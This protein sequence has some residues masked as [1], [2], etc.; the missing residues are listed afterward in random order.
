MI[1]IE[2]NGSYDLKAISYINSARKDNHMWRGGVALS[3]TAW[4]TAWGTDE[5]PL[6]LDR[7]HSQME[8]SPK[9]GEQ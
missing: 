5:P 9:L 7:V 8:V 4:D 3:T 6:V 1:S 2:F